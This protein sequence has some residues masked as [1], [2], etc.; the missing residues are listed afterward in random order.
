LTG[1][2]TDS[3]SETNQQVRGEVKG[4]VSFRDIARQQD[5]R[6]HS[7]QIAIQEVTITH[8]TS[9]TQRRSA[10]HRKMGGAAAF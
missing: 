3:T 7:Q 8:I 9:F 5:S 2:S 10:S 6:K 4:N 1:C